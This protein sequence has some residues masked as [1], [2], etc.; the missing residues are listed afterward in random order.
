MGKFVISAHCEARRQRSR[1]AGACCMSEVLQRTWSESMR[2]RPRR[3]REF[4]RVCWG[5]RCA[6]PSRLNEY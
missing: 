2:T 1:D 5:L 6:R 4:A 3:K